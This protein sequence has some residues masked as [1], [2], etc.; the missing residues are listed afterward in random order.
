MKARRN[1]HA[2]MQACTH[3][4]THIAASVPAI[5]ERIYLLFTFI[6]QSLQG[7][8]HAISQ[9]SQGNHNQGNPI[10]IM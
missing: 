7:T 3:T 5:Q 10:S 4:H 2:R 9:Y 6:A 8:S 1:M